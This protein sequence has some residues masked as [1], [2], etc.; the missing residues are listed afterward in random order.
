MLLE[1]PSC[2]ARG[3]RVLL[4][5]RLRRDEL[6]AG[7][8][9]LAEDVGVDEPCVV[10]F[11]PDTGIPPLLPRRRGWERHVLAVDRLIARLEERLHEPLAPGSRLLRAREGAPPAGLLS[12]PHEAHRE[13]NAAPRDG[14]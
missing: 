9:V 8:T 6:P 11:G 3:V 5:D 14:D 1:Q 13:G 10:A 12:P 4:G 2:G 7:I